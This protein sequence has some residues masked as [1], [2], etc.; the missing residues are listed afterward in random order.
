MVLYNSSAPFKSQTCPPRTAWVL[1]F[2]PAEVAPGGLFYEEKVG[3]FSELEKR[4]RSIDRD[5]GV[6]MLGWS[7][8]RS[9]LVF[10]TRLERRYVVMSYAM[11]SGGTPGTRLQAV[12]LDEV[13]KV[14]GVL[15]K[16]A[17]GRLRA[18]IY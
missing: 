2:E 14:V 7:G 11:K 1:V 16:L 9:V 18:W 5:A 6:R 10:V 4:L 13:E 17:K 8:K 3:T 15:R 12:E